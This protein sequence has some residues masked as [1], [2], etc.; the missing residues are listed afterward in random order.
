MTVNDESEASTAAEVE[1]ATPQVSPP[2]SPA[3]PL[4]RTQAE[5]ETLPTVE[6]PNVVRRIAIHP[7]MKS[8]I[9][10]FADSV[11]ELL[12]VN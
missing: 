12:N 4:R 2:S 5:C 10:A 8:A 11:S 1:D 6:T 3:T 9:E 7:T